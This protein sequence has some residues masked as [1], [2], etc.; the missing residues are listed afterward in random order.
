MTAGA[1]PPSVGVSTLFQ[2]GS[3]QLQK[4]QNFSRLQHNEDSTPVQV[5]QKPGDRAQSWCHTVE[6]RWVVLV[7][8]LPTTACNV[9]CVSY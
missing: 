9:L 3:S 8:G 5:V 2:S 1:E 7:N 6:E 4:S